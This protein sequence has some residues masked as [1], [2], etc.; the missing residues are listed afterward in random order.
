MCDYQPFF[1]DSIP[2]AAEVVGLRQ[3]DPVHHGLRRG[4]L[5]RVVQMGVDVRRGGK[6]AAAQPFLNPLERHAVDQ[7]E[8]RAGVPQIVKA[9]S[10]QTVLFHKVGERDRQPV[11]LDPVAH[12]VHKD[13]A[14]VG[15]VIAVATFNRDYNRRMH[16][17]FVPSFV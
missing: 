16:P 17:R 13:V 1:C 3:S 8:R 7:Q 11:R 4:K 15:V 14:V 9:H 12:L 6:V 10:R 2:P 5:R